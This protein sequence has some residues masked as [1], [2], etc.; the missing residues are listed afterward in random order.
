MG[1]TIHSYDDARRIARRR[2]P[3]MVFDYIDGAAGNGVAEARN[4]AAL[5]DVELQPRVLRNVA[6]RDIGVQV[7]EHAGQAPFGISPM[8]MCNLSGPG[9]DVM[10]ARIAAKHQVPVGVS[11]VASTSLETMIEEA[12]GH[13]WFQLYFSGDGSGTAKLV[14]RAKTAGYKTLIMTL[15]VPEVGRRPRELRRGFK[16]PFRIGPMQFI[17]FA[18]HPRWSLS[19]LMA[20][21]PDLANFQTPEFTFDR[22]ESRAAADWDFLKRLRDSWDGHLVAKGVTDVDDALQLKAQGVD[23]IQV[24]THGGR[25]LDSAPPPILALKRIRDAIGPQ[26]PLFYDTGMRSGEDV[27]K[28]YQMGAD[29]VFFGRGMQFAIAAG[30][31]D[32]LEQYWNLLADETSLTLAQMGLTTLPNRSDVTR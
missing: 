4:L 18:L 30:G 7:F 21:A 3:W 22:T 2:L 27:V 28:A 15:D 19:S 24:S 13:A 14:E 11:T 9:A 32:G 17:D 20:G 29:F 26:Y 10:L 31:R 25:Q 6:R 16:M 12:Q 8:G 1:A 23:A 5:R